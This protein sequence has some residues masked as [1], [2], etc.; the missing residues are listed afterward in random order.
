MASMKGL[1]LVAG[2]GAVVSAHAGTISSIYS[3]EFDKRVQFESTFGSGHNDVN[4]VRWLG[5]R[6][7]GTD[8]NIADLYKA[9]CVEIG[10]FISTGVE[11]TH[12]VHPL[13]GSTT[14]SG[15]ITGPVSFNATRTKNLET[16]WGTFHGSVMDDKTSAAFQLAVWETAFDD[17]LTLTDKTGKMYGVDRN[18]GAAGIQLDTVSTL[19]QSWLTAVKTGA[20]TKTQALYLLKSD[21]AQD[22]ITPVPE[23]ATMLALGAGLAAIARKRRK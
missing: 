8:T 21:G 20:A 15:G 16:L 19:A 12:N 10:E 7:G 17:D 23:P 18:A 3:K 4:T 13:L 22:L 11:T 1:L 9:Y 14:Q 2:I 5:D 6:T